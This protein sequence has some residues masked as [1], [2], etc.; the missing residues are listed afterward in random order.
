MCFYCLSKDYGF[1][2]TCF[3][4]LSLSL[5]VFVCVSVYGNASC[6]LDSSE[7]ESPSDYVVLM[8]VGSTKLQAA[9]WDW[10]THARTHTHW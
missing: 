10:D 8:R 9:Y 1:Q 3:H 4:F 2:V 7:L 6:A 5:R